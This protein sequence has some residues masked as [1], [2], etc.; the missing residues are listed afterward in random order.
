MLKSWSRGRLGG[1]VSAP[2]TGRGTD[3]FLIG[4][5]VEPA[6]PGAHESVGRKGQVSTRTGV[7][8]GSLPVTHVSSTY[9][10]AAPGTR[11]ACGNG[12]GTW[13][14]EGRP[15]QHEACLPSSEFFVSD[16]GA[17]CLLPT[18]PKAQQPRQAARKW[19]NL[20]LPA[21]PVPSSAG[22]G[23][24]SKV[25]A[26][27]PMTLC[28]TRGSPVGTPGLGPGRRPDV[29]HGP[30]PRFSAPL[31]QKGPL[32]FLLTHGVSRGMA[33]FQ[34]LTLR[35]GWQ[36]KRISSV[37]CP[38]VL[39]CPPVSRCAPPSPGSA[40]AWVFLR[41]RKM[42]LSHALRV[43]T[44]CFLEKELFDLSGCYAEEQNPQAHVLL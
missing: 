18:S 9:V 22:P 12:L 17:S 14:R 44:C 38:P 31:C 20:R 13:H 2:P 29:L 6:G 10:L 32:V 27:P 3:G 43:S 7:G 25:T 16:P 41:G 26:S 1:S 39:S 4:A 35:P 5:V 23:E 15:S 33:T 8:S 30:G 40:G 36:R 42:E 19:E 28:V 21:V 34:R 37:A 11:L 24:R